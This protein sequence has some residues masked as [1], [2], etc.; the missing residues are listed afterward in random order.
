LAS[1]I[2]S[3]ENWRFV[4]SEEM[5]EPHVFS[6]LPDMGEEVWFLHFLSEVSGAFSEEGFSDE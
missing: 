5:A 6:P 3:N 1:L 2:C 4:A